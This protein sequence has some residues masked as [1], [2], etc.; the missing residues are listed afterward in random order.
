MREQ[1][2]STNPA[3]RFMGNEFKCR[4]KGS[5]HNDWANGIEWVIF[6]EYDMTNMNVLF[7]TEIILYALSTGKQIQ[8][9]L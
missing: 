5:T 1:Q 4:L 7:I 2:V 9:E 8:E 6:D 3:W